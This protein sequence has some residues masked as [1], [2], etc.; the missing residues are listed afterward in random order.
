MKIET[1][2]YLTLWQLDALQRVAAFLIQTV[3]W[4]SKYRARS[5]HFSAESRRHADE[6]AKKRPFVLSTQGKQRHSCA[7]GEELRN[8]IHTPGKEEK[9][10]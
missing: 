1:Q 7:T 8:P 4:L 10:V 2:F 5:V 9:S 6:K 3:E